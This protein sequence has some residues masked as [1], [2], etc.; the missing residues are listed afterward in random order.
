MVARTYDLKLYAGEIV[1]HPHVRF[2]IRLNEI[3]IPKTADREADILG[4]T[5]LL[6]SEFERTIRNHPEQW[7]WSHRRWG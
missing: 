5:A 6:Q 1:R 7:M 3:K 2:T 4:A